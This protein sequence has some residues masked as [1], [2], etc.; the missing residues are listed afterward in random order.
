MISA[1]TTMQADPPGM[2]A[3]ILRPFHTPPHSSIRSLK[4]IPIGNSRLHGFS[5]W[6]ETEKITV[7]PELTRP[8]PANHAAPLRMMGGT[9][10]KLCVL[11]MMAGLPNRPRLAGY[12]G[13]KRG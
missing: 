8:N 7:P 13:L 10:A 1:G 3:F 11:L 12:C 6:P 9:E 4:G 2:T 5:T